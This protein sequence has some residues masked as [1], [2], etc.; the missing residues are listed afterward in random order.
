M[1]LV[2]VHLYVGTASVKK[3]LMTVHSELNISNLALVR[4]TSATLLHVF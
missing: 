3:C 1:K 4:T 2:L